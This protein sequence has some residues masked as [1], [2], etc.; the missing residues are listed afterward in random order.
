VS[1]AAGS[2]VDAN[3]LSTAAVVRGNRIWPLLRQA[4]LPARLV[5]CDGQVLTAGGWPGERVA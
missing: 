5:T 3:V 4:R 1:A 2:C